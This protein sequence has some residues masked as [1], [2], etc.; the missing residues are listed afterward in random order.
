MHSDTFTWSCYRA[1]ALYFHKINAVGSRQPAA[2]HILRA[3][4]ITKLEQALKT[5]R[6]A[7]VRM[8]SNMWELG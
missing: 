8:I 3:H 6:Q 1:Y 4:A 5:N 2:L 7:S